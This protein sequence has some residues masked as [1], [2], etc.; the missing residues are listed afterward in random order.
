MKK[1]LVL[2]SLAFLV[3]THCGKKSTLLG[4]IDN[5]EIDTENFKTIVDEEFGLDASKIEENRLSTLFRQYYTALAFSKEGDAT[6][7]FEKPDIKEKIEKTTQDVLK[8]NLT[9]IWREKEV[10]G[11]L[12]LTDKDMELY[13]NRRKVSH[14]LIRSGGE[15]DKSLEKVAQVQAEI[16]S[17]AKFSELAKKYSDDP[18]SK[19]KGGDL[20]WIDHTT[21]FVP[22]FKQ[23]ALSAKV[24]EVTAPV[25]TQYG[26]HLILVEEEK[27]F[28]PDELKEDKELVEKLKRDKAS[29]VIPGLIAKL[30]E[31]YKDKI[32]YYPERIKDVK[33]YAKEDLFRVDG[34]DSLQIGEVAKQMGDK[35][36]QYQDN[37]KEL[38]QPIERMIEQS[39]VYLESMEK[40][41]DKDPKTQKRVAFS[42]VLFKKNLFEQTVKEDYEK[43][44]MAEITEESLKEYYEKNKARFAK[45]LPN[46]LKKD[47]FQK[48]FLN[49]ISNKADLAFLTSQYELDEK[50]QIFKMKKVEEADRDKIWSILEKTGY[51]QLSPFSEMKEIMQRD[52][53]RQKIKDFDANLNASLLSKYGIV[54]K[55]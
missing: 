33:K 55:G 21:A 45:G 54:I 36:K 15:G 22:Q 35:L 16:K 12:E 50:S 32:H 13:K 25:Q 9:Y 10:D 31:K 27:E 41:Y 1:I 17:G 40:G 8:R 46:F 48:Q 52:L 20:G 19:E 47:E 23:A 29:Q 18:G 37:I 49:K 51:K 38:D 42:L 7:V 24:G 26:Y 14:I 44:A 6:G 34:A 5:K 39:L 28:S 11:L 30:R 53:L 2:M 43:K 4:V 3:L